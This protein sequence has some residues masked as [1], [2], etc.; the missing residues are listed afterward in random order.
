MDWPVF[1]TTIAG[2]ALGGGGFAAAVLMAYIKF[3]MAR[4][5]REYETELIRRETQYQVLQSGR[6]VVV[7]KLHALLVDALHAVGSYID[8]VEFEGRPSK[9][10]RME[11]A[12]KAMR[13]FLK[14]FEQNRIYF[15]RGICDKITNLRDRL[16]QAGAEFARIYITDFRNA[17]VEEIREMYERWPQIAEEFENEIIPLRK[18]IEERFR[19]VLGVDEE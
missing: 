16:I 13:E 8:P 6:I 1:F 11:E 17:P 4:S 7:A 9:R 5:L 3:H 14:F 10:E 2:S 15:S 19:N 12:N 18:R